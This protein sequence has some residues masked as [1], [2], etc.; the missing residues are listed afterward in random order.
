ML[1]LACLS[2]VSCAERFYLWRGG[3][4]VWSC[5][6]WF[7][8]KSLEF[9]LRQSDCATCHYCFRLS[10]HDRKSAIVKMVV[11]WNVISQVDCSELQPEREQV[12]GEEHLV[13]GKAYKDVTSMYTWKSHLCKPSHWEWVPLLPQFTSYR[14][15][16]MKR[17]SCKSLLVVVI[18]S[19]LVDFISNND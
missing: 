2:L 14:V 3:S 7:F 8:V 15:F 4:Y 13:Y 16:V 5:S 1:Y 17:T 19:L 9:W 18:V 11:V 10:S 6:P 12:T